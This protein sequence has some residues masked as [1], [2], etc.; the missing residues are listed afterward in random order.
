MPASKPTGVCWPARDVLIQV[1]SDTLFE[2]MADVE[3]IVDTVAPHFEDVRRVAI[4]PA[5][6]ELLLPHLA[7]SG[8]RAQGYV[9]PFEAEDLKELRNFETAKVPTLHKLEWLIDAA[10][11]LATLGQVEGTRD[12]VGAE[13]E[14][15]EEAGTQFTEAGQALLQAAEEDASGFLDS[16]LEPILQLLATDDLHQ[17]LSGAIRGDDPDTMGLL[18]T[19]R[20]ALAEWDIDPSSAEDRLEAAIGGTG[21]E[22]E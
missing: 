9:L 3:K 10:L 1:E 13:I 4:I 5:R 7:I 2:W 12:L 18:V 21:P 11:R 16:V 22:A 20:L 19:I 15:L 14:A 8:H 17:R 6:E